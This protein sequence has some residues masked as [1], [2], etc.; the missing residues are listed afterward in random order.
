VDLLKEFHAL[1]IVDVHADQ[2]GPWRIESC[3]SEAAMAQGSA[4]PSVCWQTSIP[5]FHAYAWDI[6]SARRA[7]CPKRGESYHVWHHPPWMVLRRWLRDPDI[8]ELP[9]TRDINRHRRVLV[10]NY[11]ELSGVALPGDCSGLRK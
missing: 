11:V 7:T 10:T 1:A 8:V 9:T 2:H 6:A 5:E 3:H 4:T